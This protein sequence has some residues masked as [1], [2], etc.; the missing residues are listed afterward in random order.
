MLRHGQAAARLPSLYRTRPVP[1][2]LIS[3]KARSWRLRP[4]DHE[5]SEDVVA[6]AAQIGHNGRRQVTRRLPSTWPGSS[7]RAA[8]HDDAMPAEE[9]VEEGGEHCPGFVLVLFP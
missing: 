9:F 3:A 1:G 8:R 4:G 7:G 6:P 2:I 5:G